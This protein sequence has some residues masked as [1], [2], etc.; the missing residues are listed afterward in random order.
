V[1]RAVADPDNRQ[2][3]FAIMIRS[4]LKGQ[5]LGTILMRKIIDYGRSRGT[6]ELVGQI[7]VENIAMR[8]LAKTLGF[9]EAASPDS[10]IVEVRLPLT[11]SR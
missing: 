8:K 2:A 3:E 1:V 6:E 11:A 7:M 4:D 5:G 9:T 10:E